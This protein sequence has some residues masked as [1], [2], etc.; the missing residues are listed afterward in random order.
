M[1]GF[2]AGLIAT[3]VIAIATDTD[4]FIQGYEQGSSGH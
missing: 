2:L 1:G 3:C 4:S